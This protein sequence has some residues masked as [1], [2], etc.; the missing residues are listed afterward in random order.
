MKK[1]DGMSLPNTLL[2]VGVAIALL[3]SASALSM[4]SAMAQTASK[5][6]IIV[7]MGDDIGWANIGAYHQGLMYRPRPTSTSWPA[8]GMRFT[9]YYARAKLHRRPGQLHHRRTADPHRPDNGRPGRAPRS[10][11]PMRPRR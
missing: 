9:D 2:K 8:E 3:T 7:I 11:C 1:E 10:E 5:P 4:A 6:N